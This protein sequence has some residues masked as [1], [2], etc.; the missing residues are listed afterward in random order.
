MEQAIRLLTILEEAGFEAFII[1]GAV[2]DMLMH[3]KPH[4]LISL[5]LPDQNRLSLY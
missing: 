1:G 5:H 2:R 4:D 3:V